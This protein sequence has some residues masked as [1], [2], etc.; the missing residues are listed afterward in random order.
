MREWCR[1]RMFFFRLGEF[2][3]R[4]MSTYWTF[5][6]GLLCGPGCWAVFLSLQELLNP[7]AVA[8]GLCFGLQF[9]SLQITASRLSFGGPDHYGPNSIGA[10]IL[11][12]VLL[13]GLIASDLGLVVFFGLDRFGKK[14]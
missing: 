8:Y 10:V 9:L 6:V 11:S 13:P 14:I 7:W 1:L 12:L 2:I 5:R 3:G 4:V